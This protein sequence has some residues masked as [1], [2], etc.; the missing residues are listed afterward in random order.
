MR[1]G[2]QG[3]SMKGLLVVRSV[4][5]EMSTKRGGQRV[6]LFE[7]F[8][9]ECVDE[10]FPDRTQMR[11]RPAT[12]RRDTGIREDH[13]DTVS[14]V[15]T[16]SSCDQSTLLHPS[17]MM[18]QTRALPSD[19]SRELRGPEG[20]IVGFIEREQDLIVAGGQLG[21]RLHLRR[22]SRTEGFGGFDVLPPDAQLIARW[23]H[24]LVIR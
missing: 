24:A 17:Q 5:L 13:I 8:G 4:K 11:H 2:A 12:K 23:H 16:R 1:A 22:Q 3:L 9:R 20:P 18:R 15:R 21:I 10:K 19:L 14:H 7:L 6:D